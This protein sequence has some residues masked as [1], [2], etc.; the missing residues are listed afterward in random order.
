[1]FALGYESRVGKDTI[2]E[3]LRQKGFSVLTFAEPLH[4]AIA[5]FKRYINDNTDSKYRSAMIALANE[6]KRLHTNEIFVNIIEDKINKSIN[7]KMVVT[8][9]RE[10]QQ[11][12]MLKK[13]GFKYVKVIRPNR[14]VSNPS[15]ETELSS[16]T[17]DIII[18]ND[19]DLDHLYKTI[20]EKL[21]QS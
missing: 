18:M 17:P 20:E 13:Y 4:V 7:N 10:I 3:Y 11:L 5:E 14:D 6:A 16:I 15:I 1:M 19:G 12:N 21:L 2:A 8:D 9:L